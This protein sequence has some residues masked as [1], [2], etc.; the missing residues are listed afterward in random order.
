M[1]FSTILRLAAI[2]LGIVSATIMAQRGFE[3]SF[4]E[5]FLGFLDWV[6]GIVSVP[7]AP[8][9]ALIVRLLHSLGV[10]IELQEHWKYA[11]VLM[12][13]LFGSF[14]RANAAAELPGLAAFVFVWGGFCA[15]LSGVLAGTV[16]LSD[17]GVFWWPLACLGLFTVGPPAWVATI[18]R[19]QGGAWLGDFRISLASLLWPMGVFIL[20]P[21]VAV[22]MLFSFFETTTA[23]GLASLTAWIGL[24]GLFFLIAG[25]FDRKGEGDTW[26][27]KWLGSPVTRIGL[28]VLAVLGGAAFLTYA[29]HV[30]A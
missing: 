5:D 6:G 13:L 25:A 22:L 10:E 4:D 26:W 23:Q 11:F 2:A 7:L 24:M 21:T 14:A 27:Q 19:T 20:L 29:A 1:K 16:P 17:P 28:D 3:I 8:L 30:L 9:G 12:W 15:L 18:D